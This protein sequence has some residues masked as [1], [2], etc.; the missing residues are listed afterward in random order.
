M[1]HSDD[2]TCW[3]STFGIGHQTTSDEE[4][5]EEE[6]VGIEKRRGAMIKSG[7]LNPAP[8]VFTSRGFAEF[9]FSF[10]SFLSFSPPSTF[11]N[12]D[13]CTLYMLYLV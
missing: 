10:L 1:Q 8:A 12:P 7:G 6:K 9:P 13:N 2:F 3:F 4:R 5:R 11:N